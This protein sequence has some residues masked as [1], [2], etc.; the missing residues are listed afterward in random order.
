MA[1][2]IPVIDKAH[3]SGCG[4]C[5]SACEP[6]LFVFET[7]AW[8]KTSVLQDADRCTGC[9]KCEVRCPVGAITMQG[10]PVPIAC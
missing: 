10:R 6:R 1:K 2:K 3:C 7:I 5:I 9:R 8:K 4:R